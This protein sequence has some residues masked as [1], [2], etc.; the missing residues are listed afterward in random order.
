MR[1][2][3]LLG[4]VPLQGL[5]RPILLDLLGGLKWT[6]GGFANHS[7]WQLHEIGDIDESPWV[8]R[9]Y[10]IRQEEKENVWH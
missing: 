10:W 9:G 3:R 1:P 7:W 5:L 4:D 8:Q 6:V 2:Y